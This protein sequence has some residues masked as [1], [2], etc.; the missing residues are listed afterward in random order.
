[1]KQLVLIIM[2][3]YLAFLLKAQNQSKE[4][5]VLDKNGLDEYLNSFNNV[6]KLKDFWQLIYHLKILTKL[7]LKKF[8]F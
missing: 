7:F 3:F 1:M 8:Y 4:L 2:I 6:K 5:F